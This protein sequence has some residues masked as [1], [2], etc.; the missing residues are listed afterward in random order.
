EYNVASEVPGKIIKFEVSEGQE[1]KKNQ[2]VAVIDTV[3]LHSQKKVLSANIKAIKSKLQNV[4][5]ELEVLAEQKRHILH[6]KERLQKLVEGNAATQKQVDDLDSQLRVLEKR[7]AATK[8]KVS[9]INRGIMAQISPLKAQLEQ[10]NERINKSIIRNPIDG[11]VL[12]V[13]KREGEIA[14]AGMPLY[15]IADLSHID[16]KVYVTG[17]QLPHIK[18]NQRVKVFIDEDKETNKKYEGKI[19][20]ISDKAEFTPKTIQTKEE[21]VNLVYAVKINLKNDGSMKIGMPGEVIFENREDN[22][23]SDAK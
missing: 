22:P 13:Y 20:W 10:V 6:E 21:R 2:I 7:I 5:P 12:A 23:S 16:L 14:G 9:D 18:L 11:Q 3:L 4:K 17:A 1:L 19:T 8:S 15:K